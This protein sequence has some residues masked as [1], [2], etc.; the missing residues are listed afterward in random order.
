MLPGYK[1]SSKRKLKEKGKIP[2]GF[3]FCSF[4]P[5]NTFITQWH[6]TSNFSR[7]WKRLLL[8]SAVRTFLFLAHAAALIMLVWIDYTF[9]TTESCNY[10][11]KLLKKVVITVPGNSWRCSGPQSRRLLGT[12]SD[13]FRWHLWTL[14]STTFQKIC[15]L[16][17]LEAVNHPWVCLVCLPHVGFYFSIPTIKAKSV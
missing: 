17:R 13:P 10:Y 16:S 5:G 14:V 11:L 12:S 1:F 2:K 4:E 8:T 6:H 3:C 7:G 15:A 9:C